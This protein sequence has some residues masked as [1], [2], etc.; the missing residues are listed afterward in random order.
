MKE[1]HAHVDYTTIIITNYG[2]L[3]KLGNGL[4]GVLVGIKIKAVV[5]AYY[6]LYCLY[7]E[8]E[9]G[10]FRFDK[11]N[12]FC[13]THININ[14]ADFEQ[15]VALLDL[16]DRTKEDFN[17][18]KLTNCFGYDKSGYNSN[19]FDSLRIHRDTGTIYDPH[20]FDT[21]GYD[22]NRVDSNGFGYNGFNTEGIHKDT[23]TIYNSCGYNVRGLNKDGEEEIP[24]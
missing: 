11:T 2:F 6:Q 16:S 12:T 20:G 14:Y 23:G 15:V 4:P 18:D 22:K 19:G 8:V 13:N 17:A 5:C 24:F 7:Q 10:L 3:K 1:I 9:P 21:C